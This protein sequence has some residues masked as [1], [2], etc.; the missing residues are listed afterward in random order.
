[1]RLQ[2]I[3]PRVGAAGFVAGLLLTALAAVFPDPV[4]IGTV[5]AGLGLTLA[6]IAA[7]LVFLAQDA[8]L[9]SAVVGGLLIGALLFM[10]PAGWRY[11]E[12]R[13]GEASPAT[14]TPAASVKRMPSAQISESR[15]RESRIA[16]TQQLAGAYSPADRQQLD[17]LLGE[18]SAILANKARPTVHDVFSATFMV[19]RLREDPSGFKAQLADFATD[20]EQWQ[21]SL[22]RIRSASPS[23][24]KQL[25]AVLGDRSVLTEMNSAVQRL[26]DSLQSTTE[27]SAVQAPG[28]SPPFVLAMRL[29]ADTDSAN[30]W[31]A[32]CEQRI[33]A[34]RASA[35]P[36]T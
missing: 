25:D 9:G 30:R 23:L 31:I 32:N 6:G 24:G 33:A 3:L 8:A 14:A 1:M 18:V 35:A 29:R 26:S 2:G 16:Q 12:S 19:K 15:S 10:V 5:Y 34:M 28:E 11:V 27:G 36:T 17:H 22:D 21:L 13:R 4:Q 7:T 20:L